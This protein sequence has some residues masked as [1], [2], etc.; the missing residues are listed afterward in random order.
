M[1]VLRRS[2]L[3]LWGAVD[4]FRRDRV[5][6]LA[7][8][9]AFYTLLSIGPL[10]YLVGAS[11][12]WVFD[13]GDAVGTATDRIAPLLPPE[14]VPAIQLLAENLDRKGSLVLFAIPG[15]LW[16]STSAF[17][18]LEYAV[19]VAFGTAPRRKFWHSRMKALLVLAGG[20]SLLGIYLVGGTLLPR[21]ERVSGLLELPLKFVPGG[22]SYVILLV[23]AFASFTLFFK[24][25]PRG[26]V[27]WPAAA[28]GACLA[29]VLW[30]G[31]R[32][33]FSTLIARSPALGLLTG[34]L[35]GWVTFMVWTYTAV[36]A[37]LLGAELAAILNGNRGEQG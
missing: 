18:S 25:L 20:W 12:N 15:L 30:E 13:L 10:L 26:R 34:A 36:G 7:A 32:R 23:T 19:N 3:V 24:V 17:S 2:A 22:Y 28:G 35:A 5:Q 27:R 4:N 8:T 29:L 9:V 33:L 21:L 31:A 16:V 6:D 37:I 1:S 14:V 11:L